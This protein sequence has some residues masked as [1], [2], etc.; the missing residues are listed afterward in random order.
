MSYLWLYHISRSYSIIETILDSVT[1]YPPKCWPNVI[2][3]PRNG[4]SHTQFV[5]FLHHE[6]IESGLRKRECILRTIRDG[7]GDDLN[8]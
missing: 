2:K 6:N 5:K 3:W 1:F 4:R 8:D 7:L